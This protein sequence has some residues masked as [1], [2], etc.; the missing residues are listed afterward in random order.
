MEKEGTTLEE[1][2]PIVRLPIERTIVE[3]KT[4]A[5]SL[6][7]EEEASTTSLLVKEETLAT[8]LPMEGI[9]TK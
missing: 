9:G 6:L 8:I 2:T 3:G 5:A 4:L 7:I 1:I